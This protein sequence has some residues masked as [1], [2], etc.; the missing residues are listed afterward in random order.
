M[1]WIMNLNG[2]GLPS[3]TWRPI[4]R[5]AVRALAAGLTCVGLACGGPISL[6][7]DAP[8]A[9]GAVPLLARILHI[10]YQPAPEREPARQDAPP[11]A[12]RAESAEERGSP[13]FRGRITEGDKPAQAEAGQRQPVVMAARQR[14]PV[15][16]PYR[17]R[18]ED[19][20]PLG[21]VNRSN[22]PPADLSGSDF[23]PVEDRWRLG[24]PEWN[25]YVSGGLLRPW[26]QSILKGDYPLENTNLFMNHT[27]VSDTQLQIRRK[28]VNRVGTDEDR[29][30]RQRFFLT[31][32]L[33][34]ND[35]SF[36]PAD[37]LFRITQAFEA[38]DQTDQ[39][40]T[41][42]YAIQE[43]FFD[44]LLGIVTDNYDTINLRVGRQGFVSD[45]RGFLYADVNNAVR[46]FGNYAANRTQWNVILLDTVQ[47]D[48]VSQF[49]RTSQ[50]RQQLVAGANI[51]RQDFLRPGFNVQASFFYNADRFKHDVDA[52]FFE[53][54]ADGVLGRYNVS[55]AFIQAFGHDDNNP[56]A[57]RDVSINAQFAA[58][59]VARPMDWFAPRVSVMYASGDDNPTDG[60]GRGFDAIF[61]NPFFAGA[62]FAFFN[63]EQVNSR[64]VRLS[65]FNS[66]LP[67]LRTKAF[68][69]ANFVN[70]GLITLN[71]G[72][73]AVLTARLAAL[74]NF[75][76]YRFATPAAV[77]QAVRN[78]NNGLN[79]NV[80]PEI[81]S[82][83]TLGVI[84]KPLI[85]ENV[86]V[87]FGSTLFFQGDGMRDLTTTSDAQYSI[88]TA[89]TAVY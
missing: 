57:G 18:P 14:Q 9:R 62:G 27:L 54:A 53:V 51:F 63:R 45:F 41:A 58:L 21:F 12:H 83:V 69:P 78:A 60:V 72:V 74:V 88:F 2:R 79:V 87:T 47:Q 84:Y 89:F 56:I 76:Y 1:E 38:R 65:N 10:S 35:N 31:T 30:F 81:G 3:R 39:G 50:D 33:F 37:W 80:R 77:E 66:F 25:R 68:D 4:L 34:K 13:L 61:D 11:P 64:G 5:R 32:E 42:D 55:S 20:Q 73:D 75:N 59:E 15:G 24:F 19:D 82:D 43:L 22:T 67:N 52:C 17:I 28:P 71:V 49:L 8:K 40:T 6:A 23:F 85:I 44:K 7:D 70:P 46:L 26:N 29:Q 16:D 86:V 36:Q 48:Q